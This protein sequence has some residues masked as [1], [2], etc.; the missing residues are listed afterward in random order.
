MSSPEPVPCG[1]WPSPISTE[2]ITARTVSLGQTW[3]DG[4]DIYWLE[5]RPFEGGRNALVRL[6]PGCAPADCL[7]PETNVR[8]RVHEYGGGAYAVFDGVIFFVDFST[9]HLM[10][11]RPGG[12]PELLAGTEGH[13]FADFQLDGRGRLICV[14]EDHTGPLEARNTLVAIPAGGGPA[15]VLAEGE[16]FYA[17]P[18][19]SRDGSRLAWLSWNHPG[20]PW[21]GTTLWVAEWDADG[22]LRAPLR[23]AGGPG[24]SVFQ[25]EWSPADE[26]HFVSDRS[27][28]W[29][30]YRLGEEAE[31]LCP[32]AAEFGMPQWNFGLRT[33][34]F[35]SGTELL[36]AYT[37]GGA[38]A[39]G[40]LDTGTGALAELPVGRT[41][42]GEVWVRGG[43]ALFK[44]G[45]A[46]E[47][48]AV[49]RLDLATGAIEILRRAF[50][51]SIDPGYL[52]VPEPVAYPSADGR[53]AYGNFYPPANRDCLVP[54]SELPPLIVMSHG[55]PTSA[56]STLLSYPLQ[57]W[58]SRGFAV[59][60]INY[61]GSTGFGRAYRTLLNGAWGV[62]DV[63]DCCL[64][65]TWLAAQGRVDPARC[66]I[67]GGS[68]GGYT[69]LAALTFKD[70]FR[71]GAS[72]YG[73]SDLGALARDT[74][75]FESRYLDTLV[76]PWPASREL[77]EARSP[78]FHVDRLATPLI[79]LQG[80]EDKV[81]PPA[82]SEVLFQALRAK[83]VPVAYLLFPGEQHGFRQAATLK[84]ACEAELYFYGRIFGFEPAEAIEPI[85][86]HNL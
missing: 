31:P 6:S 73:V 69:T 72:L 12:R 21:D 38:W 62:V 22:G 71:A 14:R 49:L 7:P 20:M 55:G 75:K 4:P 8:T 48:L 18:R 37:R 84:R 42:C 44:G 34:A 29:N 27:G 60:D 54:A 25:P 40:R 67:R 41:S 28:W 32:M 56:A 30:L 77:Y 82:Q 16:S 52:S 1:S 11:Q 33:Y 83:G 50:E 63:E 57:Y 74:H 58:T 53:T 86:I 15:T 51:P 24:E 65:A 85:E 59:L 35:I 19:L 80:A 23:V 45:S 64:G 26:L 81:V 2:L 36:C 76:G 68:A 70:V 66:A 61:G 43:T 3:C 10:R 79:L 9:Q 46:T 17:S 47:P 78:L 5:G 39:L 13:R